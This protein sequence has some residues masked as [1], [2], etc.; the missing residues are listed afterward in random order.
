MF[1]RLGIID[2]GPYTI[3]K[4]QI[5]FATRPDKSEF[6][7]I[8][9]YDVASPVLESLCTLLPQEVHSEFYSSLLVINDDIPPHIDIVELAGF[10]CYLTPGQYSTNFYTSR[11][12]AKGTEYADHGEGHI[13]KHEDLVIK[14]SFWAKPYEVFLLNNKMIHEVVN[15]EVDKPVREV[16]QLATNKYTFDEVCQLIKDQQCGTKN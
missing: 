3:L 16:L 4:K 1:K 10:N 5:E 15:I 13:Y 2:G 9:Y 8:R 11:D 12:G 6:R 7:G 14:G